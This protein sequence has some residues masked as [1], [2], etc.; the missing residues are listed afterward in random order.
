[1]SVTDRDVADAGAGISPS[2]IEVPLTMRR[3]VVTG[4]RP[5]RRR[6]RVR[7]RS[8]PWI[9]MRDGRPASRLT[10]HG[11]AVHDA[12]IL[13][14][15]ARLVAIAL[16]LVVVGSRRLADQPRLPTFASCG[17]SSAVTVVA[18]VVAV[19]LLGGQRRRAGRPVDL[20]QLFQNTLI[21]AVPLILG[22]LAGVVCERSGVI[23]VAI[24]GQLLAGAFM[25]AVAASIAHNDGVGI[26]GAVL[27]GALDR[28]A[29]GR[30]R[31]QVLGQPGD[32]RRRAQ[33]VRA[34][35]DRALLRLGD[36]E[37]PRPLQQPERAR[38]HQDPAARA[39]SRSSGRCSS[40]S[41]SSST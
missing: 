15:P 6:A 7:L 17:G 29:A 14:L 10:P 5:H 2:I 32:P 16:G 9:C 12:P 11:R 18:V 24:E 27:A 13:A 3:R 41:T 22:A 4:T 21:S 20:F 19:P 35:P 23:N 34:R 30:V 1:M 8:G 37:E 31:H 28:R 25:G 36:A 38:R 40:T 26:V 33:R 39:T